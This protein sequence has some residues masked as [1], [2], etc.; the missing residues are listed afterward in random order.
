[1]FHLSGT[2]HRSFVRIMHD[3]NA[4]VRR[5]P[6]RSTVI[7][8]YC[9]GRSRYAVVLCTVRRVHT[10]IKD[11]NK[12]FVSFPSIAARIYAAEGTKKKTRTSFGLWT[13]CTFF[14]FLVFF[15]FKTNGLLW[16]TVNKNDRKKKNKNR[17]EIY[18]TVV[19]VVFS[20]CARTK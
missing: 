11:K 19:T 8:A 14:F 7:I 2:E 15:L 5:L 12:N 18:F 17:T 6:M 16:M 20:F 10:Y 1:M 13:A 9:L 4:R 3:D